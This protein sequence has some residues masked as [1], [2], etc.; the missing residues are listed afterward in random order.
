MWINIKVNFFNN[1]KAVSRP[2]WA[3]L[4]YPHTLSQLAKVNSKF[5]SHQFLI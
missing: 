5:D 4:N 2:I 1:F 3:I